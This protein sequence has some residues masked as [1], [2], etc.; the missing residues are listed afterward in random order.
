MRAL[1]LCCAVFGGP[2]SADTC[3]A[4]WASLTQA[5]GAA[6]VVRGTVAAADSDWCVI[7]D[8][9]LDLPGD[10]VPGDYAND[11][12]ADRLRL[13]GSVLPWLA[14]QISGTDGA[15]AMP[16]DLEVEVSGLRLVLSTGAAQIDYLFAAQARAN[17]IDSAVR[18]GWDA[19]ARVLTVKALTVDFPG[20]NALALSAVVRGVDADVGYG[21]RG[22]KAGP[23]GGD[24]WAVRVVC[25]DGLGAC[26]AAG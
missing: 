5:G 9:V 7:E 2:A 24:A 4:V 25:A 1:A 18:L 23:F 21:L 16:G 17:T 14:A 3:G 26:L 20:E 12:H 6:E 19:V 13:R 22:H 11:W 10:F 15:G 8:V